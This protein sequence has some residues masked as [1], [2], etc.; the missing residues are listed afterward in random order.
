MSSN[1]LG[2]KEWTVFHNKAT[3]RACSIEFVSQI[4]KDDY[5]LGTG[6][7]VPE[8]LV[9]Q[10]PPVQVTQERPIAVTGDCL[11]INV[12]TGTRYERVGETRKREYTRTVYHSPRKGFWGKKG[13]TDRHVGYKDLLAQYEELNISE[14]YSVNNMRGR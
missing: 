13:F 14:G 3:G 1:I 12:H 6:W 8:E 11:V 2:K 7:P 4:V 10:L 9:K 5:L